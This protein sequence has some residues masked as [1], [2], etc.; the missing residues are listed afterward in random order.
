MGLFTLHKRS[1]EFMFSAVY[2][3]TFDQSRALILT[4]ET[5]WILGR[6]LMV[7]SLL[8]VWMLLGR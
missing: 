4:K 6:E 8:L 5:G 1:W 3:P 7:T 2:T